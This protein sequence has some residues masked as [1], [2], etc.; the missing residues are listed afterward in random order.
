MLFM[1]GSKQVKNSKMVLL[2]ISFDDNVGNKGTLGSLFLASACEAVAPSRSQPGGGGRGG[3]SGACGDRTRR[4]R[5]RHLSRELGFLLPGVVSYLGPHSLR[6]SE[7]PLAQ[8]PAPW[9]LHFL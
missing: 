4:P 6:P 1:K 5:G 8:Q 2:V 3:R 7:C 9:S